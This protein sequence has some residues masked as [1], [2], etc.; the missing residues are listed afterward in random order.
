MATNYYI[1]NKKNY[2]LIKKEREL[3]NKV[4]V[5]KSTQKLIK[6]IKED[7]SEVLTLLKENGREQVIESFNDFLSDSVSDLNANL[8]ETLNMVLL[9]DS[10]LLKHLGKQSVGWLFLFKYQDEWK[11]YEEVKDYLL[12]K[13]EENEECIINEYWEEIDPEELIK[14]IEKAQE[15]YKDNP[16]NFT[17]NDN[18]KGYRFSNGDFS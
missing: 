2:D 15:D 10:N 5:E 4:N 12:N 1:I 6:N 8:T 16:D 18:I 7:Y 13:L 17:Y 9:E 14:A 11:S 3:L